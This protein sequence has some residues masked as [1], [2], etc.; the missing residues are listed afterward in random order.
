MI[1]LLGFAFLAGLVTVLAPCIL[2]ILPIVLSGGAAQGK[3]RP[4]GIIL[5]VVVSFSV[6]TLTLSWLVQRLGLSPNFARTLGIVILA[7]LG[8]TMLIPGWLEKFEGWISARMSR[9]G[10]PT[11]RHG[12]GGGIVLGFS[13][14][15]VWTPCAGPILASVTTLAATSGV[16]TQSVFIT[17]AYAV[18]AA[19]PMGLIAFFG[20]KIL[21][22][23]RWLNAHARR[24]QQVFAVIVLVTAGLMATNVDRKIQAAIIQSSVN[25]LPNLQRFEERAPVSGN[26]R[27]SSAPSTKEKTMSLQNLG[28]APEL[29]GITGWINSGPKTLAALRGQV[30]L[31][32]FWTYTCINCI[33]TLPYVQ[34]WYDKYRDLGFEIVAVHTPEF[35]FEKVPANVEKAV[36]DFSITYPVALDPNYGTWQAYQNRYW[37]AKYFVDAK[38]NIRYVHFGEGEYEKSEQVIQELLR[39]AGQT[40]TEDLVAATGTPFRTGQTPET[41]FGL[42][43]AERFTSAEPLTAGQHVYSVKQ[44]LDTNAWA[45]EGEW[46]INEESVLA[47]SGSAL[48]IQ[49]RTKDVFFVLGGSGETSQS[50]N[51]VTDGTGTLQLAVTG[52]AGDQTLYRVAAFPDFGDHRVRLEFPQGGV[53]LYAATFGG[54]SAAGLACGS[55]GKCNVTA[56]PSE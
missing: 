31:I 6:F 35:E 56:I 13:L 20:Q 14:G 42:A 29:T 4:W 16:T 5:G 18:G 19:L 2:P 55:D 10:S 22:R 1:I 33:R 28:P 36:Q 51:V 43:R 34:S 12:F 49:V 50:V 9:S 7:G 46:T 3:H 32:D 15:A 17:I 23:V 40:V 54:A 52:Q 8:V 30:V 38:G 21:A 37:P 24:V 26:K 39:E 53:R 44:D 41:Y 25:Y 27:P 47:G 11:S 45:L 48:T